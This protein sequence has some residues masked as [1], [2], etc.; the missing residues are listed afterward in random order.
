MFAKVYEYQFGKKNQ[1]AI[2]QKINIFHEYN[3]VSKGQNVCT[4]VQ[5]V[6]LFVAQLMHNTG[7]LF[8]NDSNKDRAKAIVGNLHRMGITN[9]V[10]SNYDGKL[11]PK[12]RIIIV[13]QF[14]F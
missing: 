2:W 7:M 9:C 1:K 14:I 13:C 5:F 6:F 8:A 10:V 12:V 3:K 11:Y 4:A